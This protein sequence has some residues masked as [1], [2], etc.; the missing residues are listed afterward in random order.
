[1][2]KPE[3]SVKEA[4]AKAKA[5]VARAKGP[6]GASTAV[7]ITWQGI[8]QKVAAATKEAKAEARVAANPK[9]ASIAEEITWHVTAQKATARVEAKAKA[10]EA[11]VFASTSVIMAHAAL[12]MSAGSHTTEPMP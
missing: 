9:A 12:E 4:K 8:A 2:R 10:A 5:A 1:M 6:W 11:K 7:V 3:A